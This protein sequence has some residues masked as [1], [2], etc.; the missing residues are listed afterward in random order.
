MVGRRRRISAESV[1]LPQ[2]RAGQVQSTQPCSAHRPHDSMSR[3]FKASCAGKT[4]TA[5]LPGDRGFWLAKVL[6]GVRP[7]SIVCDAVLLLLAELQD[8]V[9]RE[10]VRVRQMT[11]IARDSAGARADISIVSIYWEPDGSTPLHVDLGNRRHGCARCC[12]DLRN[13]VHSAH[14]PFGEQQPVSA[15]SPFGERVGSERSSRSFCERLA[16]HIRQSSSG[17]AAARVRPCRCRRQ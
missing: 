2:C 10:S 6:T 11:S 9:R 7:T 3:F 13:N 1:D 4:R 12:P 16:V 14:G 5:A 8:E 17:F 15:P